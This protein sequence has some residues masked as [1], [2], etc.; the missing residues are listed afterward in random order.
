MSV[1]DIEETNETRMKR[2]AEKFTTIYITHGE[3]AAGKYL[4]DMVPEKYHDE[5]NPYV[6]EAFDAKGYDLV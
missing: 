1:H 3:M 2:W 4:I 5:I 6:K